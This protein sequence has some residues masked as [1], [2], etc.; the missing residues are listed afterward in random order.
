MLP[1]IVQVFIFNCAV[2][3]KLNYCIIMRVLQLTSTAT[4]VVIITQSKVQRME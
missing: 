1:L 3:R 2:S 4:A